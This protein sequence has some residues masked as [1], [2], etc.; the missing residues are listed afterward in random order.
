M[1]DSTASELVQRVVDDIPDAQ[2]A[3]AV[4]AV[5]AAADAT[6]EVVLS[7]GAAEDIIC[8]LIRE[9]LF[10]TLRRKEEP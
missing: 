2:W 9:R 5:Q 6:D 10:I 7:D 1:S 3:S 4:C 8:A